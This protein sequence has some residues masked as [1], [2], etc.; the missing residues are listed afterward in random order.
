LSHETVANKKEDNETNKILRSNFDC[1]IQS[2]L[3]I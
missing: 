2:W 1:I 3:Q